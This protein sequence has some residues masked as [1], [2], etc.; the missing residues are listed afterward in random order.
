MRSYARRVLCGGGGGSGRDV[1]GD[2]DAADAADPGAGGGAAA[3]AEAAAAAGMGGPSR[4]RRSGRGGGGGGRWLLEDRSTSTREN[5]AFTAAMV[6]EQRRRAKEGGSGGGNSRGGADGGGGGGKGDDCVDGDGV[7]G[8]ERPWRSIVIVTNPFHQ[9]RARRTFARAIREAGLTPLEDGAA[10]AAADA[11]ASSA[12]DPAL[13]L[14]VAA[15]PFD[16][17]RGYPFPPLVDSLADLWDFAREVAA[18]CWY[19]ARGWL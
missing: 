19:W 8:A 12:D 5:A 14:Y 2:C 1:D 3:A 11:D 17:H 9:W 16:G 10:A 4:R 13:R 18:V 7:G 15:A 6:A